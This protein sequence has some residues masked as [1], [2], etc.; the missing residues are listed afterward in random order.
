MRFS[1]F[2]R[3][4]GVTE[5]ET[6]VE[7]PPVVEE[8]VVEP[9]PPRRPPPPLIWP[10]LL[11]LLLL[12]LA[13]LGAWWFFVR[14]DGN[15]SSS[16]GSVVVPNVIGVPVANALAR[17][18]RRGL[19]GRVET[20]PS[21]EVPPGAVFAEEPGAGSSVPR[22]SLVTLS[23]ARSGSA[24]S[25]VAVPNV[26]GQ[27]APRATA[28]L[29]AK[30]FSVGL[31]RVA[32]NQARGTVIAQRPS[33]GTKEPKGS[34]VA[35]RVSRGASTVPAVVGRP[36]AVALARLRAAGL[37]ALIVRAP[38]AA[39]KGTVVAQSPHAGTLS[40]GGGSKVRLYVS[41]GKSPGAEP[42]PPLSPSPP[43]PPGNAK[44]ATVSVPDVTGQPQENA[45]RRLNSAGLKA[46]VVY[47]PSEEP[48]GTVVSQSP[49]SESSTVRKRGTRIQLNVSLGPSP[50]DQVAVPNVLG[51]DPAAAKSRLRAAGLEVLTLPQGVSDRSQIGKIVDEQPARGRRAPS[52]ST[53][54]IYV[55]RAA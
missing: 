23:V 52:G 2:R 27:L 43:A 11:L 22:R 7:G 54:V 55:G 38:A 32:S 46:G 50:G 3:S 12:V 47:V 39:S 21:G 40:S 26:V 28:Q 24:S 14:D 6:V 41:V 18:A 42:P 36:L 29:R 1:P 44:P 53:V 20:K 51:Q 10:W 49:G 37:E 48:E 25:S 35:I 5:A 30:G 19:V 13:G 8:E 33:A 15:G 31:I 9:P 34:T 4:R 16:S 17:V 45:Q